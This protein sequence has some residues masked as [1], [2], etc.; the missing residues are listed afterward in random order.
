MNMHKPNT[1]AAASICALLLLAACGGSSSTAGT[2]AGSGTAKSEGGGV[3]KS[4]S[5]Q[6]INVEAH[7]R[8][9]D[10]VNA[11]KAA[12][13]QGWNDARCDS[14]AEKF[15]SAAE[16]QNKFAEA[17]YMAGVAHSKCGRKEKAAA[18]YQKALR[19]NGKFCKARV[20]VALDRMTTGGGEQGA[21]SDFQ[22]A[23]RDDPQCTEGYVNVAIIQ[24]KRGETKEA[25]NNL[26]RALAIDAQYLPAFNEMALLYVQDAKDNAKMLDLAEVVCSQAQKINARYPAI[27]NTWG[28]IDLRRGEIIGAAAKFQKAFELDPKMF[29]AYMNFAQITIGFRGYEDARSAFTK[30]LE[31]QPKS[32]D[33]TVGLGVAYRG[34]EQPAK[35]E[36]YYE[37]AKQMNGNRPEPFYNLG[38]LYQDFKEGTADQMKKARSYY[39]QFL[40]RAGSEQRYSGAVE[41]VKRRCKTVKGQRRPN[42]KCI[43]GRFQNIEDYL[44]ALKDMDEMERLNK[45]SAKQQA[46]LEAQQKAEEEALKKQQAAEPPPAAEPA[47]APEGAAPAGDKKAPA[48]KDGGGGKAAPKE[49]GAKPESAKPEGGKPEGGKGKK[50]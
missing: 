3:L 34:L 11:F 31:L 8:W 35:A 48:G 29:E 23:V 32:F 18:L 9:K 2:G 37:K 14:V 10:G 22:A 46:E 7:N 21:L 42:D 26:R 41:E 15:E 36:E 43:S 24:R 40:S 12:E 27:Y 19:Q 25:L 30:A 50:K 38:V 39:E 44:Q 47:P 5:G 49:D 16:A 1:V 4:G 13:K 45:E 6:A 28:L 33:A 17:L 20:A